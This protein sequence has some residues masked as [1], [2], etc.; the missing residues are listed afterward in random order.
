MKRYLHL[1]VNSPSLWL[2]RL[3]KR[4]EIFSA[5]AK[6]LSPKF[7]NSNIRLSLAWLTITGKF[8]ET[9]NVFS[10]E[11]SK[12]RQTL[13]SV[14]VQ[15]HADSSDSWPSAFYAAKNL[16]EVYKRVYSSLGISHPMPYSCLFYIPRPLFSS[17][18]PLQ[19]QSNSLQW[20]S[21]TVIGEFPAS[22]LPTRCGLVTRTPCPVGRFSIAD[23]VFAFKLDDW[24]S[25]W[26]VS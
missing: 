21:C 10:P 17:H 18:V 20:L 1:P 2:I 26:T 24:S 22:R 15:F 6:T 14:L 9:S 11:S 8:N 23:Y 3:N 4:P 19:F 12:F 25:S 13:R 7:A 5:L 16:L